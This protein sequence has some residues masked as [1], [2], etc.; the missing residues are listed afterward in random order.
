MAAGT[1]ELCRGRLRR[2]WLG[3]ARTAW[4]PAPTHTRQNLGQLGPNLVGAGRTLMEVA[5]GVSHT[6]GVE[7][8]V[9]AV[10]YG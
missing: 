3:V 6:F 8:A 5:E 7:V 4:E 10:R 1:A 9:E 2:D